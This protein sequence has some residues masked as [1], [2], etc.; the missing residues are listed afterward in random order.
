MFKTQ[1]VSSY[2]GFFQ[3]GEIQLSI[4][5]QYTVYI[6]YILIIT[7]MLYY[8]QNSVSMAGYDPL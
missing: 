2:L 4:D 8:I 3:G 6:Y 5:N 1:I 7:Y